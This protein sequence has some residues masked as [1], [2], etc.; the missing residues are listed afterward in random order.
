M[1]Y[2][3]PTPIGNLSDI[4]FRSLDIIRECENVLCED[5]RVTKRLFC[6]ISQRYGLNLSGKSFISLH[7]HNEKQKIK[8]IG[9]EILKGKSVYVTDAG[10]P[11]IS[12]PGA[13]LVEF[14]QKNNIDYEFIP[15]AN[16]ALLAAA[17]SGIVKKEFIFIGFLPN[18][19][20]NRK[21]A[22]QNATANIY[23]TIIYESPMKI[24]R[25]LK[26]LEQICPEREIFLI[27]EATKKFET[28]LK[29]SVENVLKML[30]EL[31]T[32]GEWCIVLDRHQDNNIQNIT[33]QDI[34]EL[35]IAPKHKAKLISKITGKDIKTCYEKIINS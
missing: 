18:S 29:G 12:D 21:I 32:S 7:S 5:T 34:L 33:I 25:L 15:G 8:H 31:N 28:K 26:D 19:G 4:S 27:K 22:I 10:M 11:C 6:L 35:N 3:I 23:P 2:F 9:L 16:A 17:A 20:Q 1:F 13:F 30:M 14:L 24:V